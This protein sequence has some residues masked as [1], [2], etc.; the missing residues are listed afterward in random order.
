MNNCHGSG[1]QKGG[2]QKD[3]LVKYWSG[4]HQRKENEENRDEIGK[5]TSMKR[6]KQGIWKGKYT[7]ARGNWVRR[8]PL[9]P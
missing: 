6:C 2:T 7:L 5:K 1:I 8:S 9:Q 3:G 4:R